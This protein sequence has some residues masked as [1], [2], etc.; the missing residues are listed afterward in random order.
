MIKL[1]RKILLGISAAVLGG[2]MAGL[3]RAL[4]MGSVQKGVHQLKG[5]VRINDVPAREGMDVKAGDMVITGPASSVVFVTNKDAFMVRANSSV[6]AMGQS[7][8]LIV[9]G[10]R[11]VTGAVLSVFAR[12]E[13]KTIYTPTAIFGIR[14]TGIYIEAELSRAYVCLCYGIVE[15]LSTADPTVRETLV[16]QYHDQPFYVFGKG[17]NKILVRAPF[18][19]HKDAELTL[20]EGL[21]GRRPPFLDRGSDSY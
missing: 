21:T 12:D 18:I 15:I 10:L 1:K 7:G 14:G 13:R 6:E 3:R 4:A 11:I 9:T 8:E 5:D 17:A 20:L 2:Y 19:N 16:T